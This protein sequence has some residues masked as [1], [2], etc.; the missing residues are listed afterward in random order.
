MREPANKL[1]AYNRCLQD[2]KKIDPVVTLFSLIALEKFAQISEYYMNFAF[3]YRML[4]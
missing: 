4:M 1:N 2:Y 3:S